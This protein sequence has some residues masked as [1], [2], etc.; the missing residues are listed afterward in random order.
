[1]IVLTNPGE[2]DFNALQLMGVNVKTNDNPIGYFGTGLKYA[3]AVLL[4]EEI[5]FSLYID[6]K[7]YDFYVEEVDFRGKKIPRCFLKGPYDYMALPFTVDHGKNWEVW[8]A[9]RELASNCKDENGTIEYGVENFTPLPG[10]T[11]F[12][13]PDLDVQDVFLAPE[14]TPIYSDQS[15]E[16]YEG[17]SKVLYYQGI[18]AKQLPVKSA[19]TWNIKSMCSLTED[20]QLAYESEIQT[21]IG[22]SIVKST[23]TEFI[24][25]V[26]TTGEGTY[27]DRLDFEGY[28]NIGPS[29]EF[30]ATWEQ[31]ED[32]FNNRVATYMLTWTKDED[33]GQETLE[34]RLHAIRDAID[35]LCEEYGLNY[36][37]K[38][39]HYE[40]VDLPTQETWEALGG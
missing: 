18:R 32:D 38:G 26:L 24:Y 29:P 40:I 27:E 17:E 3:I 36:Y 10:H 33:K 15:I 37:D 1:M 14:R 35:E 16:V 30:I 9:F 23:D 31:Y 25:D 8:M 28:L 34:Q 13:L 6:E 12:V 22:I 20:R 21:H 2:I 39:D 7:K 11:S 19:Y 4:R 5:P